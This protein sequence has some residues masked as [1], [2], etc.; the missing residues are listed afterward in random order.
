MATRFG[1]AFVPYIFV[2]RGTSSYLATILYIYIY[3]SLVE[4]NLFVYEFILLFGTIRQKATG[5]IRQKENLTFFH[6]ISY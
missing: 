4:K 2:P 3:H 1:L 5:T 6:F